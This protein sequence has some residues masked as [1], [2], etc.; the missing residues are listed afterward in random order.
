[1]K[2]IATT[3][4]ISGAKV[5]KPKTLCN[6]ITDLRRRQLAS[7][8]GKVCA[9]VPSPGLLK[10]TSLNA[11]DPRS[12]PP[13]RS[14]NLLLRPPLLQLL[15]HHRP[16]V[17]THMLHHHHSLLE[18]ITPGARIAQTPM[19]NMLAR[20]RQAK[21]GTVIH[22]HKDS[23]INNQVDPTR[24]EVGTATGTATGTTT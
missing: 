14:P 12:R 22:L 19:A 5:W 8:L 24:K 1:V 18:T 13:E 2:S 20:L 17:S 21:L 3:S 10:S 15:A 9:H 7:N 4:D 23:T 16:S 11:T 6:N